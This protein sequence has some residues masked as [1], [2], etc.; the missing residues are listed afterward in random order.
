MSVRVEWYG[1]AGYGGVSLPALRTTGQHWNPDAGRDEFEDDGVTPADDEDEVPT[2]VALTFDGD[3]VGVLLGSAEEL[4]AW[5]TSAV[6]Q[7]D[8]YDVAQAEAK[9]NGMCIVGTAEEPVVRGGP[10]A[11]EWQLTEDGY[12]RTWNTRVTLDEAGVVTEVWATYIG[13][14]SWSSEGDG[15]VYVECVA[16]GARL[17][18][19]EDLD[20]VY[21]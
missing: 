19:P 9:A 15:D 14:E 7:L 12:Q 21:D 10:E 13:S 17:P 3:E 5:L 8:A 1:I 6:K 2:E 11:H 4:R 18:I 16:C 20:V